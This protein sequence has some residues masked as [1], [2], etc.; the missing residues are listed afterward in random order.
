MSRVPAPHHIMRDCVNNRTVIVIIPAKQE[1]TTQ[2]KLVQND[3]GYN[4]Y[5]CKD[6]GLLPNHVNLVVPRI[7]V[8]HGAD[9]DHVVAMLTQVLHILVFDGHVGKQLKVLGR[10]LEDRVSGVETV[11]QQSSAPRSFMSQT[12]KHLDADGAKHGIKSSTE[13]CG[14]Y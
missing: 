6:K 10:S 12:V 2:T 1:N 14:A 7:D 9:A 13:E 5:R 4:G 11:H 8:E 3:L